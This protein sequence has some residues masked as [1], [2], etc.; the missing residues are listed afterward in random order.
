MLEFWGLG[1][2]TFATPLLRAAQEQIAA[3]FTPQSMLE[4]FQ[5]ACAM[6]SGA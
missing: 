3:H 5:I 1:D 6:L 4:E 2:L